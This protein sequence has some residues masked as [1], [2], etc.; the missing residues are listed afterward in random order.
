MKPM[1]L[2]TPRNQSRTAANPN[3][4]NNQSYFTF[5]QRAGGF[6]VCCGIL[7]EKEADEAANRFDGLVITG[8]GD[9]DPSLYQGD[10][11]KCSDVEPVIDR[12]D[13]LLYHAFCK[14][15]KPVLGICRG[16]QVIG[17]AEG[18]TLIED[19]PSSG[20][21]EHHQNIQFDHPPIDSML[22]HASFI[23]GTHL[24]EIFGDS[25]AIN[26][27]HHQALKSVPEG[28]RLAAVSPED[29]VIE[30]IEKEN[31]LAVQWHPERLISDPKHYEIAYQFVAA[32]SLDQTK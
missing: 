2:L 20:S 31:V 25:Y 18:V 5:I 3:A 10:A 7:S 23:P 13:L 6:P 1:I 22:Y 30:A 11:S 28:F 26:S 17:V 19:L 29:H 15:N 21:M 4:S 12:N 9:V 14:Q 24:H 27:F 32:C 8:G 16:I